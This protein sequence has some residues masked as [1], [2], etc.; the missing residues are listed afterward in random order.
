MQTNVSFEKVKFVAYAT[1]INYNNNI[2]N[3]D[4]K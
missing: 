3:I 2:K 1:K 4:P